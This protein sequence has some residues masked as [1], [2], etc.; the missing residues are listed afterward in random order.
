MTLATTTRARTLR[1]GRPA[2]I[3]AAH[4]FGAG[5]VLGVLGLASSG[6]VIVRLAE[7]WRITPATASHRIS[8]FGQR[9]SY[10]PRTSPR[11]PSCFW[12]CSDSRSP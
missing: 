4:A 7:T 9:L 6:F 2:E 5:I 12:R 10:P 3:A 11:S 8:L 1:R